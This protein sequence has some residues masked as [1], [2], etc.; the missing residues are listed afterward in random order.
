MSEEKVALEVAERDF[1]RMCRSRRID[2]DTSTMD[3]EDRES[4]DEL[5]ARIL[6]VMRAGDLVV[7]ESGT[8]TYTPPVPDSKPI[9]FHKPTGATYMAMDDAG[10]DKDVGKM[11][12]AMNDITRSVPGALSKLEAPDFQICLSLTNL[13]LASR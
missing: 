5:K 8:P 10:K 12:A 7:D 2:I 13:F 9:T 1:E 4:F 6:R 11:I 3:R